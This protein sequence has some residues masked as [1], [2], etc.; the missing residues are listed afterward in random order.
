MAS[1]RRNRVLG[2]P[3]GE[4]ERER[5]AGGLYPADGAVFLVDKFDPAAGVVLRCAVQVDVEGD[6]RGV[7]VLSERDVLAG[8]VVDREGEVVAGVVG[9]REVREQR[10]R[11]PPDIPEG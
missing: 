2:C 5:F 3:P 10:Q 7:A 6:G 9:L 4:R 11:Q 1:S 8:F